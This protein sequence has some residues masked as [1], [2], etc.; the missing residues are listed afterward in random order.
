MLLWPVHIYALLDAER[1]K[2]EVGE[3]APE[4]FD[5]AKAEVTQPDW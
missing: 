5:R 3:R 4:P 1:L 2:F